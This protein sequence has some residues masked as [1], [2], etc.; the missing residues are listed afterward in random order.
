M[1]IINKKIDEL[2]ID[3]IEDEAYYI[4]CKNGGYKCITKIA[5]KINELIKYVNN[6]S[7]I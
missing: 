6:S 3:E 7:K 1:S 5:K 4:Y 2:D